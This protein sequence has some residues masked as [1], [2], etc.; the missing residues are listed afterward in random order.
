MQRVAGGCVCVDK[1]I[2][3]RIGNTSDR[4][5]MLAFHVEDLVRGCERKERVVSDEEKWFEME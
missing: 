1:R 4:N 5:V 3:R 2:C